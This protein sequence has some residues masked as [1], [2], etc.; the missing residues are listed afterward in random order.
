MLPIAVLVSGS[1]SNLQAIL[2]AAA[3]DPEFGAEVAV[4]ISDRPTIKAL[5]RAE[6]AGI[7]SVVVDWS[8]Y[9]DRDA[10]SAAVCDVAE[11]RGAEALVLAGFMRILAPVAI[12]RFPNRIIN[13]HPAL[14]PAFP[15]AHAI[16][17]ALEHGVTVTGLTIHFVD[18]LVDN[19]PIIL[20]EPVPVLD[21]D[22][23]GSLQVRIQAEEHRLYPEVVKALAHGK[24]R[25]HGR[26]VLWEG[27]RP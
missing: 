1:G 21:G 12:D 2:D 4:V 3:A 26:R 11:D 5:S 8:E 24:L 9:E 16:P 15:G 23:A 17:Q 22:D 27:G 20:Q 7:P 25:V 14:L 10:F 6:A 13:T 18:E 19:G